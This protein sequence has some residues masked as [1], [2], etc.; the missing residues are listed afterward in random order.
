MHN[1]ATHT[2]TRRDTHTRTPGRSSE[3]SWPASPS[4]IAR[5]DRIVVAATSPG[6]C[7]LLTGLPG[8]VFAGVPPFVGVVT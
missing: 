6:W 2:C 3:H 5:D 8:G 4:S 1:Q 7:F